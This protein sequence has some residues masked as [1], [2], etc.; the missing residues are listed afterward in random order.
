MPAPS[1]WQY[2][3]RFQFDN[4]LESLAFESIHFREVRNV[5]SF[6]H[7]PYLYSC[8][9]GSKRGKRDPNFPWRGWTLAELPDRG[10]RIAR[11]LAP[12]FPAGVRVLF[13]ASARGF[14]S[15]TE[16]GALRPRQA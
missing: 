15:Q 9:G 8:R 7:R 13:D 12:R 16:S 14:G 1:E 11:G 5:H 3:A 10:G 6:P 4:S 2:C